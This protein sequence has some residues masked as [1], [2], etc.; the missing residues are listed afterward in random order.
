MKMDEFSR[1][2]VPHVSC[3][4]SCSDLKY[5]GEGGGGKRQALI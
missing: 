4:M 2:Q 5:G 3:Q 1:L